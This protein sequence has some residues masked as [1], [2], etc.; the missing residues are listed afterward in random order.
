MAV[1]GTLVAEIVLCIIGG[2]V[3]A[4]G[5]L[6]IW[7]RS[8]ARRRDAWSVWLTTVWFAAALSA[9]FLAVYGILL[10]AQDSSSL[11]LMALMVVVCAFEISL[12]AAVRLLEPAVAPGRGAVILLLLLAIY[13]LLVNFWE[14]GSLLGALTP[15]FA[16]L[17]TLAFRLVHDHF[18]HHHHGPKSK[19]HLDTLMPH[20]PGFGL[21]LGAT[22]VN[23]GTS[24][25]SGNTPSGRSGRF[26]YTVLLLL[27]AILYAIHWLVCAEGARALLL[28]LVLAVHAGNITM[29]VLG[30][31]TPSGPERA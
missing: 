4:G 24:A 20:Q 29:R 11:V 8:V 22:S 21:P 5:L 10:A 19:H 25:T 28:I 14:L 30:L 3:L 2:I 23:E 27:T 16:V 1:D 13:I 7:V 12:V 18:G 6:G 31:H 15:L 26:V 17:V 9:A